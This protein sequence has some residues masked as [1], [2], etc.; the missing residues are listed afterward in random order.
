MSKSV[1]NSKEKGLDFTKQ[2]MFFGEDLQVQQYSDMKYPIFDKLINNNLVIS[3][4]LKRFLYKK[5][6]MI[7]QN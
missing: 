6:E 2:P 3:G 5:I 1:F 4:D 7:M